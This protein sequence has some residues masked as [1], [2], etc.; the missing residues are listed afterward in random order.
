MSSVSRTH[1]GIRRGGSA[2]ILAEVVDDTGRYDAR[3]LA[4]ELGWTQAM[5]AGYVGRDPSTISRHGTSSRVQEELARLAALLQ[6]LLRHMPL[7]QARAWLRTPAAALDRSTPQH[8]IVNGKIDLVE[9]L[10]DEIESGFA[11]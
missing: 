6:K 9:R 8:L 5:I 2:S 10:L 11:I 4:E 7:N 1:T 3:R